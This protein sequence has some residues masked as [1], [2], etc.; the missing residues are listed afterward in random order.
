MELE[1]RGMVYRVN[2]L[3]ADMNSLYHRA[4]LKLG[5]ADSVSAVLYQ[6]YER[7]GSCPL[8]EIRRATGL[9]KQTIHSA[10]RTLEQEGTV[11]LEQSG[12]RTKTARLTEQGLRYAED[13]VGRL[14]RAE[15]R[16]FDG[17][18]GEDLD[19]Y[20]RLMEQYNLDLRAQ[21]DAM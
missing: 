15:C 17:W 7:N 1:R 12:G 11:R 18:S 14:F 13:T 2:S 10:V 19:R 8:R 20:L 21:I 6:L 3:T 16:V 9:S 4:A 5:L